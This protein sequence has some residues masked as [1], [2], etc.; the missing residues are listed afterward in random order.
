VD[1]IDLVQRQRDAMDAQIKADK[2]ARIV[3]LLDG[4]DC[5][6]GYS[7]TDEGY[8]NFWQAQSLAREVIQDDER[9]KS[10]R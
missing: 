3:K 7:L 1:K 5:C 9:K 10:S 4:I 2:L 8:K 6:E